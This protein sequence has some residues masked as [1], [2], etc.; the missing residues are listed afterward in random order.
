MVQYKYF[1]GDMRAKIIIILSL[2]K[3]NRKRKGG[4]ENV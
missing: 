4:A 2:K 1:I 3:D